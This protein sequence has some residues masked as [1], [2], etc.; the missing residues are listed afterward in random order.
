MVLLHFLHAARGRRSLHETPE[1]F[2]ALTWSSSNW[3]IFPSPDQEF[4]GY[5]IHT[6]KLCVMGSIVSLPGQ[7][8]CTCLIK[9]LINRN[10]YM[11]CWHCRTHQEPS[12]PACKEEKDI[13]TYS[14]STNWWDTED[15]QPWVTSPSSISSR[16]TAGRKWADALWLLS[17]PWRP[18]SFAL[19]CTVYSK[20][21][22][23]RKTWGK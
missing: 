15:L 6:N 9:V 8:N 17:Y 4:L 20:C 18:R 21:S 1:M 7:C 14:S 12:Q 10:S 19:P 16:T 22:L 3:Q 2:Q 5:I 13:S 11:V 23:V